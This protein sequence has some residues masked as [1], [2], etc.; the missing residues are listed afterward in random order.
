MKIDKGLKK[1]FLL[2]IKD[3]KY[4]VIAWLVSSRN[5]RLHFA[6]LKYVQRH[7]FL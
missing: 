7:D 2:G 5:L 6:Q 1:R 3:I 4:V